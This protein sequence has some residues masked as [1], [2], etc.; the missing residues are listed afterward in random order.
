MTGMKLAQSCDFRLMDRKVV[1]ELKNI[2]ERSLFL[3]GIV[4][5]MGFNS[6]YVYYIR[7]KRTYGTTHYPFL[8][9]LNLALNGI[10]SFSTRPLH[11][12]IFFGII[13][14]LF[15]CL[16]LLWTFYLKFFTNATVAGWTSIMCALLILGGAQLFVMGV[17]GEYIG[18]LVNETKHRPRYIIQ[19]T[20]LEKTK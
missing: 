13:T 17:I 8:K 14:S 4:V 19:E 15:G 11:Y 2:Q 3:R 16:L 5:W 6:S 20:T 10:I 1:E 12:I 9:M 18:I 7:G